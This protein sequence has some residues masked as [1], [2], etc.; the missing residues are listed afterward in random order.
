MDNTATLPTAPAVEKRDIR[1]VLLT[2]VLCYAGCEWMLFGGWGAAVPL[3]AL[4]FYGAA[5]AWLRPSAQ[6]LLNRQSI[7]LLL[8][9]MALCIFCVAYD[10]SNLRAFNLCA[11]WGLSLLSLS[12]MA[13]TGHRPVWWMGTGLDILGQT[14]IYPFKYITRACV[15]LVSAA[16]DAKHGRAAA[17]IL[18]TL[19]II[20]PLL[21]LAILLLTHADANFGWLLARIGQL[22]SDRFYQIISKLLLAALFTSPLFS[23]LFAV[24]YEKQPLTL[25]INSTPR[26]VLDG[27]T[28]SVALWAFS[29]LYLLYMLVQ[30]SYLFS[31]FR[32]A[33][34]EGFT[35]ASY[36]R[37][38]FFELLGICLLNFVLLFFTLLLTK[39]QAKKLPR[40]ANAA[41]W[42]FSLLT[43]L[44]IATAGSKMALYVRQFGLTPLRVYTFWCMAAI[45]LAVVCILIKLA[46][47]TFAFFRFACVGVLLWYLLLNVAD[48]DAR[49][50]D[51]NIAR[52]RAT[53]GDLDTG[54][55]FTLSDSA[56]PA[57]VTLKDDPIY[58]EK[59]RAAL[60]FRE[61]RQTNWQNWTLSKAIADT[62]LQRIGF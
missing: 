31:A 14:F 7:P 40:G 41:V 44:L 39:K 2:F 43:L 11:L 48:V 51:Y 47:P 23:L 6:R 15:T 20:S 18:L 53:G 30:G 29:I 1:F 12:A 37:R 49:V 38:G 13:G 26:G 52:Y 21:A 62:S 4:L 19:V 42:I 58:G 33:L 46:M 57:I 17:R 35:Y 10:N 32:Q 36:A 8:A 5:A 50:A 24:K 60:S 9:V 56:V 25:R 22:F 16:K 45:G 3:F 55:L 34:P 61:T 27:L 28:V 54:L 59:I